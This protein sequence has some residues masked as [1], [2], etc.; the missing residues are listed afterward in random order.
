MLRLSRA[1][2]YHVCVLCGLAAPVLAQYQDLAAHLPTSGNTL[3]M[4]DAT[5]VYA[6]A[7]AKREHWQAD[8]A[9]GVTAGGMLLPAGT[10]R[11]AAAANLDLEFLEPLWEAGV[12]KVTAMPPLAEIAK[13]EHVTVDDLSG[14]QALFMPDDSCIVA[15]DAQH[16][17]VI[18]PA[19]RQRVAQWLQFDPAKN[20]AMAG[21]LKRVSEAE[22]EHPSAIAIAFNLEHAISPAVIKNH[23]AEWSGDRL[24]DVTP[25]ELAAMLTSVQGALIQVHINDSM[26]G[27]LRIDFGANV[28]R[29]APIAKDLVL[30][31]LAGSGAMVPDLRD[32]ELKME[33]QAIILQGSVS[34]RSLERALSI[35]Q[36]PLAPLERGE[37]DPFAIPAGGTAG[38][39]SSTVTPSSDGTAGSPSSAPSK[40]EKPAASA[41]SEAALP[42]ADSANYFRSVRRLLTDLKLDKNDANSMGQIGLWYDTYARKIEML[43]QSN[44]DSSLVQ[45][46]EQVAGDLRRAADAIKQGGIDAHQREMQITPLNT[47]TVRYSRPN[48]GYRPGYGYGGYHRY[49]YHRGYGRYGYGR[50][51]GTIGTYYFQSRNLDSERRKVRAQEKAKMAKSVVSILED[52]DTATAKIRQEMISKY[53]PGF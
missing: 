23:V 27:R 22:A 35:V 26:I 9:R 43:P 14:H 16:L 33:E 28:R 48:Y 17:G 1:I 30:E 25:D 44:V 3:V 37:P 7:L 5:R 31:T 41:K 18:A 52:I 6:S 53:G 42:Y 51:G 39:T 36:L 50:Y 4:I 21:Y 29:L 11:L 24:K 38:L 12:V 46:G 40:T 47:A 20:G 32:W 8:H 2:A 13:R 34:A 10:V 45:Y 19:N 15:F 49:G